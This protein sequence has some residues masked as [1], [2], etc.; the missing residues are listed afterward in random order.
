[1]GAVNFSLDVH[2]VERINEMLPLSVFFETG[3]FKGDTVNAMLPY[4]DRLI[5]VE[6]SEP[7]WKEATNRFA[8]ERKV[9]SCLGNSADV[10]AKFSRELK[11]ASVLYWLDAHWCV[12]DD[13]SGE[14][15]QCP[16]LEEIRAIGELND[17]SVVLIDDARL[18]LAAPPEPHEVSH[19]PTLDLIVEA[20]RKIGP[21]HEISV[22]NDVII[23]A[24]KVAREHVSDYA[25]KYGIDWLRATQS[26]R[27]N[28]DLMRELEVR[29]VQLNEKEVTLH[30]KE[31][32]LAS[33]TKSLNEKEAVIQE[34]S[35]ALAA[36]RAAES[37]Q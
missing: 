37:R 14:Q 6:L 24:P 7:L 3:T 18:F 8:G 28:Q 10:I 11:D 32:A 31:A 20:L 22:V 27:E 1:M 33:L 23:Y 15:S 30:E 12:A 13:T 26:L 34:L 2:L 36:Y 4:F 29:L 17:K 5:T 25:R 19:W 16:L 21:M 35:T 9:E